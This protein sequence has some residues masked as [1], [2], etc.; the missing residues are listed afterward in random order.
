MIEAWEFKPAMKNHIPIP[1][2]FAFAQKFRATDRDTGVNYHT[3]TLLSELESKNSK[4]AEL[5]ALDSSPKVLYQPQPVDMRTGTT[6]PVEVVTIEFFIDPEG[7]VQLPRIVSANNLD[8]GWAAA[9][10]MKR[11][12]YEVP[13]IKGKPVFARRELQ[14]TFK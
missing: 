1:I 4:I 14:F 2:V 5:D 3:Q 6:V 11:W 12:I 13:T 7:F 8:L 10:A 9:T